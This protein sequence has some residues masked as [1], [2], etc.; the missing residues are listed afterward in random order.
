VD[1]IHRYLLMSMILIAGGGGVRGR[2]L[3]AEMPILSAH[4]ALLSHLLRLEPF[5]DAMHVELMTALTTH[6][7][8]HTHTPINDTANI[9]RYY[10]GD[11][12]LLV[13]CNQGSSH[14]MG[15]GICRSQRH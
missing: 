2:G 3:L 12:R 14:R 15:D 6:Y 9:T 11:S 4:W 5:D 10:R 1:P 7:N 8:T 13:F